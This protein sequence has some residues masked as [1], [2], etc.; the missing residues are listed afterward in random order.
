MSRLIYIHKSLQSKQVG[1]YTWDPERV[2]KNQLLTVDFATDGYVDFLEGLLE[3]NIIDEAMVVIETNPHAGRFDIGNIEC[4]CMPNLDVLHDYL[5]PDDVL[6]MRGGYKWWIPFVD[7]MN[8]EQRW[9]IFY[10]AGTRRSFWPQWDVVINDGVRPTVVRN[11]LYMPWNKPIN[12]GLFQLKK[13]ERIY[14]VCI[15]ASKIYDTKQQWK[16][17]DAVLAYREKYGEDL[18]CILPG[19]VRRGVETFRML[20][21]IKSHKLS[22]KMPGYVSREALADIFNQ[23]K[24]FAHQ[25]TGQSDR[26]PLEAMSTGVPLYALSDSGHCYTKWMTQDKEICRVRKSADS[27]LMAAELRR[28][29]S[30]HSEERRMAVSFSANRHNNILFTYNQFAKLFECIKRIG[31]PDRARMIKEF[32]T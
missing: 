31:K 21:L 23:S 26:G 14:D 13:G 19:A 17:V 8:K 27:T 18:R 2:C 6:L 11:K 1:G 9:L 20:D 22:V 3:R 24:I 30:M 25:C 28:W 29:I 4:Y 12:N 7:R 5:R 15:G 16:V 10:S 32:M